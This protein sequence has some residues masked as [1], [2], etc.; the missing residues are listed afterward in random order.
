[1]LQTSEDSVSVCLIDESAL[2]SLPGFVPE[3]IGRA[4]VGQHSSSSSSSSSGN[5]ANG[6][7]SSGG[8]I[9]Q[10]DGLVWFGD[11]IVR[12][13]ITH[14]TPENFKPTFSHLTSHPCITLLL[15]PSRWPTIHRRSSSSQRS[16]RTIER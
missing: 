1:M 12:H 4:A 7:S 15:M 8:L 10:S 3:N 14:H 2:M 11:V 5:H 16:D 6:S 9:G 13:L